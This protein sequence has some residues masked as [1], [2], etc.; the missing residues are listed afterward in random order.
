MYENDVL[1]YDGTYRKRGAHGIFREYYRSGAI[2][3]KKNYRR[4]K[5]NGRM[6]TYYPDGEIESEQKFAR[7]KVH[8][9][10]RHYDVNGNIKEEL[11][12]RRGR[13]NGTARRVIPNKPDGI[14]TVVA[15]YRN[16]RLDGDYIETYTD[17][18]RKITGRYAG[19]KKAGLWEYRRPDGSDMRTEAYAEDGDLR[20]VATY[21]INGNPEKVSHLRNGRNDGVTYTYYLDGTLKSEINWRNG[22]EDGKAMVKYESN[23]GSFTAVGYYVKGKRDG[24]YREDYDNDAPRA[25]GQYSNGEKTGKWTYYHSDGSIKDEEVY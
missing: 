20:I 7:G 2:K 13:L 16:D 6:V 15:G 24:E 8:G 25:R 10:E 5:I 9:V 12:Y 14:V 1:L 17:G 23:T 18:T 11:R 22:V 19:G 3:S 21:Y 4:G